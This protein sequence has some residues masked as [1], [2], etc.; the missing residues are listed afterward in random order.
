MSTNASVLVVANILML[1]GMAFGQEP[2]GEDDGKEDVGTTNVAGLLQF[3]NA[4]DILRIATEL[5][6]ASESMKSF[7]ES[8]NDVSTVAAEAAG[9][10]SKNLAAIGGEFDPFGFKTAFKTIQQQNAIIQA[11]SQIIMELQQKEIRRLQQE[12][13]SAKRPKRSPR[14]R[15][16]S[17]ILKKSDKS[18]L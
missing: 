16:R 4:N 7:G 13:K 6:K 14:K 2:A 5:R 18:Q 9:A 8:L 10:T 1:T 3:L 11:Q 15:N 12:N 17:R